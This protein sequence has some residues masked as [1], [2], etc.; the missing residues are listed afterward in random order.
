[1]TVSLP[2]PLEQFIR[3]KVAAGE[4]HSVDEVVCEGLRLLQ[5]KESWNAEAP[6]KMDLGWKQAKSGQLRTPE[7]AQENLAAR[8]EVWKSRQVG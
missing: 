5:K 1:M 8:K 7:Q 6:E 4:F 3:R 2:T